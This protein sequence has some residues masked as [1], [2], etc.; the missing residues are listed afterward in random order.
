MEEAPEE[1]APWNL[2][3]SIKNPHA[4]PPVTVKTAPGPAWDIE[5]V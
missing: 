5:Q 2:V 3:V 1:W 4:P